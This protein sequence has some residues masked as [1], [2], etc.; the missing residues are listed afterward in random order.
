M[1]V[2]L[3]VTINNSTQHTTAQHAA[4]DLYLER[5]WPELFLE[6]DSCKAFLLKSNQHPHYS[7]H[8]NDDDDINKPYVR[9]SELIIL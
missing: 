5:N 2:G 9:L 4:S 8:K 6:S 3:Y 7:N 1:V